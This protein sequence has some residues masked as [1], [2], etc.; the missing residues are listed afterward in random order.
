MLTPPWNKNRIN[1]IYK[2]GAVNLNAKVNAADISARLQRLELASDSIHG[3]RFAPYYPPPSGAY[4]ASFRWAEVAE[5]A[6]RHR[7]YTVNE[8]DEATKLGPSAFSSNISFGV[9]TT[10]NLLGDYDESMD[11]TEMREALM[12]KLQVMGVVIADNRENNESHLT[13]VS[14]GL[15][16]MVHN[17]TRD[18]SP[19]DWLI[20][21]APSREDLVN[22][23]GGKDTAEE[24]D[25]GRV[26]LRLEPYNAVIHT[27]T[28]KYVYAALVAWENNQVQAKRTYLHS[29]LTLCLALHASTMKIVA[30]G[31]LA[32]RDQ[33]AIADGPGSAQKSGVSGINS[34]ISALVGKPVGGAP[35]PPRARELRSAVRD[36]IFAAYQRDRRLG[37]PGGIVGLD[38][39]AMEGIGLYMRAA[40]DHVRIV[41]ER[42][43]GRALTAATPSNDV[44][45]SF[46]QPA[47]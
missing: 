22:R 3:A 9:M 31:L 19:G 12:Q 38:A 44:D 5:V 32:L 30:A 14:G 6:F 7:D 42:V 43:I 37:K 21:T 24:Q 28:P 15:M 11:D 34:T 41:L 39:N 47:R 36:A 35:V 20:V 4:G 40:A 13:L 27:H 25:G 26:T 16:T 23:K 33:A 45:I 46:I 18:I 29:Y 1:P 2:A 8:M 10:L 17:G